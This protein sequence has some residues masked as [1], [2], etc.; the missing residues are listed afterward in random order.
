MYCTPTLF[1]DNLIKDNTYYGIYSYYYGTVNAEASGFNSFIT[2]TGYNKYN[3][4]AIYYSQIYASNNYWG[5]DPP[6]VSKFYIDATSSF[7]YSNWLSSDPGAGS[8][9]PKTGKKSDLQIAYY[10]LALGRYSNAE[11][12][13]KKVID[14]KIDKPESN[15]ALCGLMTCYQK[16]KKK[17]FGKYLEEELKPRL[18]NTKSELYR[19]YLE[20]QA[21][22][23][24]QDEKYDEA[25]NN[26]KTIVDNYKIDKESRKELN[27]QKGVISL[28]YKNNL[29]EAKSIF[30]EIKKDF[31]DERTK[32]EIDILMQAYQ[33]GSFA[34][35]KNAGSMENLNKDNSGSQELLFDFDLG[36]NYPNPFNPSTN[37]SFSIPRKDIVTIKVFDILGRE[38]ALLINDLYEAGKY[39]VEFNASSVGGGLPSGIYFYNLTTSNGSITKKMIL[40]K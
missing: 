1:W 25:L 5:A 14:E 17:E 2:S 8:S 6:D 37:I 26:L 13:F 36:Q 16:S 40:V 10:E 12:L 38:V 18:V 24:I 29:E 31:P 39:E 34:S 21:K 4:Y 19:M 23:L 35:L 22:Y 27:F 33:N 20:L 7:D 28:I 30:E 3:V 9:L 15:Y 32:F 11:R